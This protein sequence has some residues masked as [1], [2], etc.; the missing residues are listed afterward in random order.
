MGGLFA[1]QLQH[2]GVNAHAAACQCVKVHF[3][4][5]RVTFELQAKRVAGGAFI[6][7]LADAEN[8]V[9]V[10][11]LHKILFLTGIDIAQINHVTAGAQ[12]RAVES[13]TLG[14]IGLGALSKMGSNRPSAY[15]VGA[16]TQSR[17][18]LGSLGQRA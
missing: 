14:F 11:A 5:G 3:K 18:G 16:V 13:D 8:G 6:I 17:M 2:V 10:N 9:A 7:I 12:Q 15:C 1:C 4:A